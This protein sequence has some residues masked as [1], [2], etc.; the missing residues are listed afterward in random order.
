ME[1]ERITASWMR[2]NSEH[3]ANRALLKTSMEHNAQLEVHL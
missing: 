1:E 2:R 3:V